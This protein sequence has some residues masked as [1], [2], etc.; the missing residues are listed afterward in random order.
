MKGYFFVQMA[1]LT[2]ERKERLLSS[3]STDG[4]PYEVLS[5][6]NGVS[7]DGSSRLKFSNSPIGR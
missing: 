5:V 4:Y 3:V 2:A 1:G 7:F 6:K